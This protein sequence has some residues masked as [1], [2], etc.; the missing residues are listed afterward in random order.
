MMSRLWLNIRFGAYHLQAGGWSLTT[1]KNTAWP[2]DTYGHKW[3]MIYT[4]F[5]YDWIDG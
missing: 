1:I 2:H 3:F 5:W 4:L